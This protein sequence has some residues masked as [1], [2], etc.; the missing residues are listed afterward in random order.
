MITR[1]QDISVILLNGVTLVAS[2]SALLLPRTP[3]STSGLVT[4]ALLVCWSG[5]RL[6]TRS[7]ARVFQ[8]LDF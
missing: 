6:A 4:L 3:E 8:I 5:Y 1:G 7:R 2:I